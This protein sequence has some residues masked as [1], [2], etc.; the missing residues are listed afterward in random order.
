M[1]NWSKPIS[2]EKVIAVTLLSLAGLWWTP[3]LMADQRVGNQLFASDSGIAVAVLD[4]DQLGAVRGQ[5]IDRVVPTA[6]MELGVILW[7][8]GGVK[9]GTRSA[10]GYS[11]SVVTV[12]VYLEGR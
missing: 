4:E 6:H 3:V 2:I 12:E 11:N 1:I 8:E 5:G 10:Q 9:K 7:D